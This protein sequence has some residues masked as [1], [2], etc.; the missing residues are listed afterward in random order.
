MVF[1]FSQTLLTLT[2]Q[3]ENP[4]EQEEGEETNHDPVGEPG[5]ENEER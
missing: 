3:E 4:A 5:I 2:S 1:T